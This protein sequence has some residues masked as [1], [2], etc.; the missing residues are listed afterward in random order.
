MAQ[1][2]YSPY[3]VQPQNSHNKLCYKVLIV[4]TF[5]PNCNRP[6]LRV[7]VQTH[8]N[9]CKEVWVFRETSQKLLELGRYEYIY[10]YGIFNCNRVATRLQ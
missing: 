5:H 1:V 10:I 8:I 2:W 3:E 6:R 4:W 7:F 9:L